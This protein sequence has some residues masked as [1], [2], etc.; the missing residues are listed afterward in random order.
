M[1][2]YK[3]CRYSEGAEFEEKALPGKKNEAL[4]PRFCYPKRIS[5]IIISSSEKN[6]PIQVST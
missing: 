1:E 4:W 2:N 3:F 6:W 5:K